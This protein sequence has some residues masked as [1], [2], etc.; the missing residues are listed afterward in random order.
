MIKKE[1]FWKIPLENEG[2]SE[3]QTGLPRQVLKTAYQ[4]Y[5]IKDEEKWIM[6]L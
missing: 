5:M 3:L 6:H 2:Y 4:A 1:E